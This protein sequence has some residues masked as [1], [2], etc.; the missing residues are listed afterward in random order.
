VAFRALKR[1]RSQSGRGV[2]NDGER[3]TVYL[4]CTDRPPRAEGAVSPDTSQP[5]KIE[6]RWHGFPASREGPRGG[7]DQEFSRR[8]RTLRNE[9]CLTLPHALAF[10]RYSPSEEGD[11]P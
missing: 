10:T 8:Q 6:F 1:A 9:I 5:H 11:K 2:D 4:A 3:R 7:I